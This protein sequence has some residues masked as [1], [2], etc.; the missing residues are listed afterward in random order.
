MKYYWIILL[1]GLMACGN[2]GTNKSDVKVTKTE[3]DQHIYEYQ[4]HKSVS[5]Y[6]GKKIEVYGFIYLD[7]IQPFLQQG[8][9]KI[10]ERPNG[11]QCGVVEAKADTDISMVMIDDTTFENTNQAAQWRLAKVTGIVDNYQYLTIERVELAE[12]SYPDYEN[13]GFA[14][15]T[16]DFI[17]NDPVIGSHVYLDGIINSKNI[18]VSNEYVVINISGI[19]IQQEL[20]LSLKRGKDAN[21]I[22]V[23]KDHEST[24]EIIIR[25]KNGNIIRGNKVRVYGIWNT[26]TKSN[27]QVANCIHVEMINSEMK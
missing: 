25:D 18:S 3:T 15:V 26:I 21:Q 20:F 1:I 8:T 9:Y 10:L 27:N 7:S 22:E 24:S 5:E 11:Y 2:L 12:Y 14:E 17:Q 4:W 6:Q 19:R 13:S 23:K 16:N